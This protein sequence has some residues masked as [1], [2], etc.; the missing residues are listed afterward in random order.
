ML[1]FG[2]VEF[3]NARD[4]EDALRDFNGKNFMGQNIVVEFA[5]ESRP[6]REPY[7]DRH[8]YLSSLLR[9][10]RP[11]AHVEV[12]LL[13]VLADPLVSGSW[14]LVSPEIPVGRYE[15]LHILHVQ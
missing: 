10:F 4:A 8:G 14:F 1:G 5:K 2:F 6:R 12:G 11:Y 3:E 7:E 15:D 13:F 9:S